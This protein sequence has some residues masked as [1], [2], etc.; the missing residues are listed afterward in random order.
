MPCSVKCP[1]C[2]GEKFESLVKTKPL[3][4]HDLS[5]I[6]DWDWSWRYKKGCDIHP[7]SLFQSGCYSPTPCSSCPL[8]RRKSLFLFSTISPLNNR[9]RAWES[10]KKTCVWF[11][12]LVKN[13]NKDSLWARWTAWT[14]R[15]WRTPGLKLTIRIDVATHFVPPASIPIKNTT[16]IMLR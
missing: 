13:R 3:S 5:S 16:W 9:A 12:D 6:F 8:A 15:R 14:G 7:A 1:N 10:M 4:E 11:G 2:K